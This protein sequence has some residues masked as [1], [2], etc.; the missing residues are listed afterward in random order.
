MDVGPILCVTE[1]KHQKSN[2]HIGTGTPRIGLGRDLSIFQI[3]ESPKWFGV[4]SN[5]G[6]NTYTTMGTNYWSPAAVMVS[7]TVARLVSFV[8]VLIA[9]VFLPRISSIFW[10]ASKKYWRLVRVDDPA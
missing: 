10:D 3:E 7:A 1:K 5:L 9:T 2:P 8:E 4:H 6:T